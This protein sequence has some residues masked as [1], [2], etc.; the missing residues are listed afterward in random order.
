MMG[1]NESKDEM[2][3]HLVNIRSFAI[4]KYEVTQGQW[5]AVMGSNPSRFS[6]CGDLCPV[7]TI[8]W[9]DAQQFIHRLNQKTG[10]NYRLPSEA[11]WE[12]AARAGSTTRLL[13][14]VTSQA[15]NMQ[16]TET[17]KCCDGHAEGQDQ[18]LNLAPVG[19]FSC[20]S[21]WPT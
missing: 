15:A 1:S 9:S 8:S 19:Q 5:K 13:V 10:K 20:Q 16:T 7:E 6:N 11:E 14:G 17:D 3:V 18:W 12:Y 21:F 4:G 2:P